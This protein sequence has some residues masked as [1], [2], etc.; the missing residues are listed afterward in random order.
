MSSSGR[1]QTPAGGRGRGWSV[2]ATAVVRT[3][4]FFALVLQAPIP[5][6]NVQ[7]TTVRCI[8]GE[9]SEAGNPNLSYKCSEH[10]CRGSGWT[11][12]L[13]RIGRWHVCPCSRGDAGS[14]FQS[15]LLYKLVELY[16]VL[17]LHLLRCVFPFNL[18][19]W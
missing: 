1:Q 14:S 2:T 17:S 13:W 8:A 7:R 3:I 18:L 15:C 10:A 6:D 19:I 5:I 11:H 16:Q 4:A 12:C 9:S